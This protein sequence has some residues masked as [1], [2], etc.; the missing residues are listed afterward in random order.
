MKDYTT[1]LIIIGLLLITYYLFGITGIIVFFIVTALIYF[2]VIK[3]TVATLRN[4]GKAIG[5]KK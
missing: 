5:G 2:G 1:Y 4:P 3:I